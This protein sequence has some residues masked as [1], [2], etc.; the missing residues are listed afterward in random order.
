[1]GKLKIVQNSYLLNFFKASL[2]QILSKLVVGLGAVF[3]A[4]FSMQ[5]VFIN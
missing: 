3:V 1:M 5:L 2:P 4:L